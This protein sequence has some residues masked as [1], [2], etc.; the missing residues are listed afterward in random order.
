MSTVLQRGRADAGQFNTGRV[1]TLVDIAARLAK[2]CLAPPG[3]LSGLSILLYHRVLD[4]VDPLREGDPDVAHFEREMLLVSEHFRVLPLSEA[5]SRLRTGTLPA[6]AACV[7]FDDGYAD[8]L[9]RALPV[10]ERLGLHATFFVAS[11]YLDGGIMWNDV[12][13]EVV[14]QAQ[15]REMTL[16]QGIAEELGL[17]SNYSIATEGDRRHTLSALIQALKYQ[18]CEWRRDT[19][20]EIADHLGAKLPTDLMM[21]SEQLMTLAGSSSADIGGHTVNHP[22][23]AVEPDAVAMREISQGREALSECL[24][25]RVS[26]FAYPNGK[27]DSDYCRRHVDMVRQAGFEAAVTTAWGVSTKRSPNYELARFTPW[28]V[29]PNRYLLRMVKNLLNRRGRTALS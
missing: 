7:T 18:P 17:A 14:A 20:F 8:N 21:S 27:P 4:Q 26:L 25:T 28:D 11:G 23:L 6:R 9:Q 5:V 12:L 24:N 15:G 16:P 10:L 22:I 29:E 3:R 13:T 2:L 19:A 1:S